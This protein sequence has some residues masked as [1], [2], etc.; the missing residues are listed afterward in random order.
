MLFNLDL[1]KP[2]MDG[3]KLGQ[4]LEDFRSFTHTFDPSNRGLCLSN[5]DPIRDVH[6]SFARQTLFELDIRSPEKE[7]N[8]HF[9]TYVPVNG[10]VY[11]LDGLREAPIDLGAIPDNGDWLAH[12]KPIIAQRIENYSKGEIHFN[13][14]GVI[15]DKK[16]KF[17]RR[18]AELESLEAPND[19]Q[20]V[21]MCSLRDS[22]T[23]EEKK[24]ELAKRENVRRRHNY[25]PFI[26]ELLK[27]L[28]KEDR[29]V[30]LVEEAQKNAA[31]KAESKPKTK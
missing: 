13:L 31:A 20:V 17:Q 28:A 4:I 3:I 26:V 12:V 9:I 16:M 21:E 23:E 2:E 7:E 11:E 25:M 18:L 29:L 30:P 15:T 14:M 27:I 19:E 22:I 6:N 1:A 24:D 10:K 5:S 8:Y